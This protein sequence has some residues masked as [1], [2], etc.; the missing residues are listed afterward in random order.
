MDVEGKARDQLRLWRG[1]RGDA[2]CAHGYR[3]QPSTHGHGSVEAD[4]SGERSDSHRNSS[5]KLPEWLH[6]NSRVGLLPL[7]EGESL[8]PVGRCQQPVIK[9]NDR[10]MA[11]SRKGEVGKRVLGKGLKKDER[12]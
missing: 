2:L 1:S 10:P 11:A 4:P 5:G 3:A 8:P 6:M 9:D 7:P 12:V